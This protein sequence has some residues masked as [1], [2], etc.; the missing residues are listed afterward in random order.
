MRFKVSAIFRCAGDDHHWRHWS[1]SANNSSSLAAAHWLTDC[2]LQTNNSIITT[3]A[4]AL[5]D[6]FNCC[7]FFPIF[8]TTIHHHHPSFIGV[9]GWRWL[10]LAAS[11]H[12]HLPFINY[13]DR[14]TLCVCVDAL[15]WPML[16]CNLINLCSIQSA[17]NIPV[18]LNMALAVCERQ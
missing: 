8:I 5:D 18:P 15:G 2:S 10:G 6:C 1:A 9:L 7:C 13:S 17:A 14:P 4:A 11:P 12:T 3:A 16:L